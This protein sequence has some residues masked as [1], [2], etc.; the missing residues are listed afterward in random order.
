MAETLRRRSRSRRARG[1]RQRPVVHRHRRHAEGVQG[2]ERNR[3]A[4]DVGALYDVSGDHTGFFRELAE[5]NSRRGLVFNVTG[6]LKPGTSV[7]QAEANLKT[8]ARQLEQEYPNENK[9]RNV[10]IVPLAQA[11]INPGFRNNRSEERRVGKEGGS[12]WT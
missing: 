6:R 4:G 10:T 8:I 9:G 5:P 11:T 3:G 12:R 2:H 7:R 1:D